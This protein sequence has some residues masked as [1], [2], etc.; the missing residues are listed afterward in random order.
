MGGEQ[1]LGPPVGGKVAQVLGHLRLGRPVQRG[2]R[3]VDQDETSHLLGSVF[4]RLLAL[5]HGHLDAPGGPPSLGGAE[6]GDTALALPRVDGDRRG[7]IL[8]LARVRVPVVLDEPLDLAAESEGV[9]VQAQLGRVLEDS[10]VVLVGPSLEVAHLRDEGR[11]GARSVVGD[12]HD[13]FAPEVQVGP[14]PLVD[15]S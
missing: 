7:V 2:F 14:G 5:L 9:G 6:L 8:G 12:V 4:D 3:F 13:R 15:V 10:G 11:G 1:Q